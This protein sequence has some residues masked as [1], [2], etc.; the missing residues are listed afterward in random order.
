[1]SPPHYSTCTEATKTARNFEVGMFS[2][3]AV[4]EVMFLVFCAQKT[5]YGR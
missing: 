3:Q 5:V 2:Q 1:M 4:G